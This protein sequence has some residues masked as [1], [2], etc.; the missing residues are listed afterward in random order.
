MFSPLNPAKLNKS[1]GKQRTTITNI[2]IVQLEK[3][4][5]EIAKIRISQTTFT[6]AVE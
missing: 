4:K 2:L 5:L 6:K 1:K 3:I